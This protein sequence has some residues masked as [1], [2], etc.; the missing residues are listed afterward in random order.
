M[1]MINKKIALVGVVGAALALSACGKLDNASSTGTQT[2][3][4]NSNSTVTT[5]RVAEGVYQSVLVDGKYQ[6]G[7]ATGV[8]ASVL[9][10][11]YN[12]NNFESGLLRLSQ[13]SFSVDK[14]YFQEGQKITG[15]TLKSWL[16]RKSADNAD[17]LNPEDAKAGQAIQKILEYN[18]IDT[19]SNKLAGVVIGIALNQVDYS[20]E[21]NVE[22]T[23]D[24]MLAQGRQAAN[25]ILTRLRKESGL[26]DMP[27][28]IALFEQAKKDD[29]E[30]GNYIYGALSQGTA[31]IDKWETLSENHILLPVTSGDNEATKDGLNDAFKKFRS[32]T[33]SFFP[34]LTGVSAMASYADGQLRKLTITVQS[35][36]YSQAEVSSF[37]QYIAKTAQSTFAKDVAWEITVNSVKGV[38]SYVMSQGDK[39]PIAHI[40]E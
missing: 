34:N 35:G 39:D 28:Y 29:V 15:L 18:F 6:A 3:V 4:N 36:Y 2:V 23:Q 1:K 7:V 9:N 24:D 33:T 40:F 19:G 17:G 22:L 16:A 21:P 12:T 31:T 25:S 8:D 37:T 32:A 30:G 10:S 38:Q 26:K 14:Y 27:I 5:G 20:L 13:K 11:N